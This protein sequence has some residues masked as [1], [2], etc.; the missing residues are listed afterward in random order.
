MEGFINCFQYVYVACSCQ[1][2]SWP[3]FWLFRGFMSILFYQQWHQTFFNQVMFKRSSRHFWFSWHNI[4]SKLRLTFIVTV[5]IKY[6]S[7]FNK[8]RFYNHQMKLWNV[9]KNSGFL[10]LSKSNF[11]REEYSQFPLSDRFS[12]DNFNRPLNDFSCHLIRV[13]YFEWN[14]QSF[15]VVYFNW[16]QFI[17]WDCTSEWENKIL[18]N[19]N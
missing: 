13:S 17:A 10:R 5:I 11:W 1:K 16:T 2:W 14:L 15:S 6:W 9:N 3:L 7:N 8:C 4:R 18:E 12:K 19:K